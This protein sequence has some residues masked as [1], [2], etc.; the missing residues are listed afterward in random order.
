MICE[1]GVRVRRPATRRSLSGRVPAK[2]QRNCWSVAPPMATF[3]PPLDDRPACSL[4]PACDPPSSPKKRLSLRSRCSSSNKRI[5][6]FRRHLQVGDGL[7]AGDTRKTF[8]EILQ[9][10]PGGEVLDQDLHRHPSAL[11]H[12]RPI[13]H[14]GVPGNYLFLS[15]D[16][17][18]PPSARWSLDTNFTRRAMPEAPSGK[19]EVTTSMLHSRTTVSGATWGSSSTPTTWMPMT[20]SSCGGS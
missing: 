16:P 1:I 8:Q 5:H 19:T 13:H 7:L 3:R 10:V 2:R 12:Q 20:R 9:R 15:H 18:P 6:R 4:R 17:E 14:L 11:E